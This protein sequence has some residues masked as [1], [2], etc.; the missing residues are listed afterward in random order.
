[1][2]ALQSS[3]IDSIGLSDYYYSHAVGG[4]R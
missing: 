2:I 3:D 4:S 1:M